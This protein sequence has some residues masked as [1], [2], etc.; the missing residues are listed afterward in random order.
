[1]HDADTCPLMGLHTVWLWHREFFIQSGVVLGLT[2][3]FSS[4]FSTSFFSIETFEVFL[5]FCNNFGPVIDMATAPIG[6]VTKMDS[7]ASVRIWKNGKGTIT[8]L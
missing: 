1:M 5:D 4:T 2:R 7:T 8:F 6:A 3:W